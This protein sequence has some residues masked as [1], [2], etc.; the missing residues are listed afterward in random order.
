MGTAVKH[1]FSLKSLAFRLTALI[2]VAQAALYVA[3]AFLVLEGNAKAVEASGRE[4]S[5]LLANTIRSAIDDDI[6]SAALS[7]VAIAEDPQVLRLFSLRDRAGLEAYLAPLYEKVKD[8][9][10]RF[11]FFLPDGTSFLR[12]HAPSEYGDSLIASRPMIREALRR[13]GTVSGIER[14]RDGLGLRVVVPLFHG[15]NFL[16]AVEYGMEFGEAFTAR[17]KLDPYKNKET[18]VQSNRVE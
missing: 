18:Q 8:R 16:G 13:R 6:R 10:V 4:T 11:H 5:L 7:I 2:V 1:L 14:G 9:I 17:L 3:F 12:I 15:G